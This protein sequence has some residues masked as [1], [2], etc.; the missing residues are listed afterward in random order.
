MRLIQSFIIAFSTYSRIPM[1]K[2]D[3]TD[4]NRRYSMCFFPLI[5]LAIGLFLLLWLWICEKIG[6]Q[7]FLK[8]AIAAVL[9]LLITGGIHMDGFMDTLDAMASWQT[10]ERRLEILKDSHT[11][12]FAVMGCAGYLLVSAGLYC[13]LTL[14]AAGSMC[15]VFLLSRTLSAWMLSHMPKANPKGM[16]SGFAVSAQKRVL[17]I[18]CVAYLLVCAATLIFTSGYVS[19]AVLC[20]EIL[21]LWY[22]RHFSMKHFGGI[23]GDLAGWF[24]Q[25]SEMVGLAVIVLGGKIL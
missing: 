2:A 13:E 21:A 19:I 1:P 14:N 4:E 17:N 3:W 10:R 24:V 25:I 20:A 5:G 6:I 8:G 18:V 7:P 15:C 12:A 11:G 23:T 9:P 16:L 22:Y